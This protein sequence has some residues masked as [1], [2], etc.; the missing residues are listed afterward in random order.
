MNALVEDYQR[1]ARETRLRT[2][3]KQ[4]HLAGGASLISTAEPLPPPLDPITVNQVEEVLQAKNAKLS[5][6]GL[7]KER[8]QHNDNVEKKPEE[9]GKESTHDGSPL[10][11]N[12][13]KGRL[14]NVRNANLSPRALSP[15]S[16]CQLPL[17]SSAFL[18]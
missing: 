9:E 17:W 2:R 18:I 8:P 15:S 6:Q 3:S 7:R 11:I 14:K 10:R 12:E 13:G 1:L 5:Y 16:S 4:A